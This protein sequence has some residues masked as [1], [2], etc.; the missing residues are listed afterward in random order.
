MSISDHIEVLGAAQHNLRQVD[1][2][3]PKNKLV[4]F[5]GP[6]G[7]GKSS[8]AFDTLYAEGQR[9]YVESLSSYARQFLGQLDK[10]KYRR[11]H[12]LSPTIAIQQK[13]T[14]HNPRSTVGTLTE[15]YDLLRL[16]YAHLGEQHCPKCQAP[17]EGLSLPRLIERI[18]ELAQ[19]RAFS[20]Q[21]RLV[22]A[23]KGAHERCFADA[24]QAGFTRFV[25]DGVQ[26]RDTALPSLDKRRKHT[27]DIVVD[28]LSGRPNRARLHESV[29]T[30]LSFGEGRLW[31]E[32][33]GERT[34]LS[35]RLHCARCDLSFEPLSPQRFSFNTP[36]GMCPDCNGL[37]HKPQMDPNLVVPDKR[38]SLNEGAVE[39]WA[40]IMGRK[41]SW[42]QSVLGTVA[43]AYEIG[44]DTPFEALTPA[45][46]RVLLYGTGDKAIEFKV[47]LNSKRKIEMERPF[48]GALNELYRRFRQTRSEGMRRYYQRFMSDAPC[49]LC[50]GDR[51]C[52]ASAAVRL[53]ALSLPAL[54]RRSIDQLHA[55]LGTLRLRGA[56]KTIAQEP[57][58]ELRARVRFLRQVGLGYLSLDR[59]G[60]SLSG[61]ESQRIRLARQIGSELSGVLYIL[62]EPSIGLHPKDNEKLLKTLL[63]LRDQGNSVLVVE[64]DLDTIEAADWVVDFG[65]GAGAQGGQ[66]MFS[67]PPGKLARNTR[68]PTG[69]FLGA[70]TPPENPA[71]RAGT[72]AQLQILGARENNLKNIDVSIPLGTLTTVTGVSGAGKS[73]LISGILAPALRRAKHGGKASPGAHRKL[74]GL[75]HVQQIIEVDQ[76]PIGRSPRSNP[77]TYT[78][79]FDHIREAFAS[80]EQARMQGFGAQRFSFNR[81]GGRCESCRGDG[82]RRVEMHF[83]PDVYVTCESCRGRRFNEA[84]L[85][86]GYRGQSIDQVLNKTVAQ[87]LELFERHP[88]IRAGLSA[89]EDVGLGYLQLGQPSNT[90]SGGEA[91][92]IKLARELSRTSSQGTVYVLDEPTTGL[93]FIDLEKL[94]SVLGKLVDAGNTV[95]VVEHHLDVV[96]ASDWVIDLGPLGG[97][98]GGQLVFSGPPAALAKHRKSH[99]GRALAAARKAQRRR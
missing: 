41:N 89:L 85:A 29:E 79:I 22:D 84:T 99:T 43:R 76:K 28:R 62:D 15:I 92:R 95:V 17:V 52:P 23:Q 33:E 11:I 58:K 55:F 64:H 74:V 47:T 19:S 60:P 59:A 97:Q 39:H 27:I 3:I 91:Q 88:K 90:L 42:T 67:G 25:V 71:P 82:T 38:K 10:P 20:I 5:T 86:V 45:Q 61:G 24:V 2:R 48:E 77:A 49:E 44:L 46:Q 96:R 16:L 63:H 66:L 51:L 81:P 73:T 13:T 57:L 65:P 93:H 87:C 37:G 21:A 56:Q 26:V 75:E 54:S 6:S 94:L 69:R 83:L 98:D 35:Q 50:K 8:L 36:A 80:T 53:G 14:G 72:G 1:L 32:V 12:G 7:S 40:K 18:L 4:V 31:I 78:K 68:A 9:R 70:P 30:A 34:M